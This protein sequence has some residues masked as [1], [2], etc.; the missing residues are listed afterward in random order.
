MT[1]GTLD[2]DVIDAFMDAV[3]SRLE[4]REFDQL[5]S[6]VRPKGLGDAA[7]YLDLFD[8]RARDWDDESP[9]LRELKA[10]LALE[11][12]QARYGDLWELAVMGGLDG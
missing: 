3:G 8:L 11:R 12:L 1:T 10:D 9:A 2:P 7:D 4:A 6:G 5:M